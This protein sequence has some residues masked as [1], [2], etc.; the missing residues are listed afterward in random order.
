MVRGR[1][2]RVG[3]F[4]VISAFLLAPAAAR[5]GEGYFDSGGVRIRYTD[6]GAGPPVVLI[7]GFIASGDLNWR[8][9]GVVGLLARNYRVITLDNRGHGKS[10]KPTDVG[11]YGVKMVQDA[12]RLL[13]HLKIARAHFVGYSMGGMITVKLAT[14]APERMLSAVVGGMGWIRPGSPVLDRDER[15]ALAGPLRACAL[16]FPTLGITREELAAIKLP[17]II[18]IGA[19]DGLL[20]RVEALREVRPDIPVVEVPGANHL[21]CIFKPEFRK[22]I[23]EFLDKQV[24]ASSAPAHEKRE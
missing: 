3:V 19:N 10:D 16:A 13:D 14:M 15:R 11:D 23:K 2:V 1:L 22:A 21:N 7:H 9:P 18:V 6:E 12:L 24:A 8:M 5:G 17:A 4:L 20:R